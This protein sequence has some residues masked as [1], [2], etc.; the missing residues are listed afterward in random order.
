MKNKILKELRNHVPFTALATLIAMLL[1]FIIGW[2]ELFS[3]R[4]VFMFHGFHYAHVLVSAVATSAVFY[5]Y[6]PKFILA[7]LIGMTGAIIIGSLSDIFL[8]YL[9]SLIFN[10]NPE[11]HLPII[12]NTLSVLAFAFLGSLSGI[13]IKKSKVPHGLHVFLSV[14][15][16]LLYLLTFSASPESNVLEHLFAFGVVFISV[17]IPC[18][19]SDIVYPL[20]FVKNERKKKT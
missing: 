19:V 18:C 9:G 20:L 13:A 12:T 3:I 11:F 15:A 5:R 7:I 8:P 1:F 6:K 4:D 16:S 10:F 17:I 14:F 2:F